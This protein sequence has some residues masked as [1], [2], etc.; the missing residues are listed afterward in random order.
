ME[1]ARVLLAEDDPDL[2][3]SLTD[4]L[5]D[6]GMKVVS[7][8]SGSE[9]VSAL[10]QSTFDVVVTDVLMP[11]P[12]GVQVAAMA[13]T[14]GDDVPFLVIT[15]LREPWIA[16]TVGQLQ[17]AEL[18]YKPFGYT[19]FLERVHALVQR[20]GSGRCDAAEDHSVSTA[21]HEFPPS[22]VPI[23]RERL[24]ISCITDMDDELLAELLT[25]VFFAGLETEEGE[26]NPV[27]VLFVGERAVELGTTTGSAPLYRWS[28]VRFRAGRHFSARE[29]VKLAAA[30]ASERVFTEVFAREGRLVIAGL[31]REG[32]NLEGDPF[33]KII[34]PKPGALSIRV[35]REHVLDYEHG[36][37]QAGGGDVILSAGPV[38]GA[39]AAAAAA[40][41]LPNDAIPA[42]LDAVHSL[43]VELSAHGRG[44][45][46]VISPE[47][48]PR[49][50]G[51][52]GYRTC[53]GISLVSLLERLE[54]RELGLGPAHAASVALEQILRGTFSSELER[55]IKELGALTALDGAT[56]LDRSLSLAGFGVVLPVHPGNGVVEALDVSATS[57]RPY[58]LSTRG[59]RH[60]AAAS[61]AREHP[62]SVVFVAS[63]DGHLGC[64][65]RAPEWEGVV[66]WR[67]RRFQLNQR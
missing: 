32:V 10:A 26:R 20:C 33:L 60:R 52:S 39:L 57:V 62:N 55:T 41:G 61:F 45:I 22:L 13:R 40:C 64:L 46:L 53:G 4:V 15:G 48:E 35:G 12:A 3:A 67:M 11:S 16:E 5:T 59:T 49:I 34:V 43:V 31:V 18:L 8:E 23:L 47:E 21:K 14:A 9:A 44:G 30:S 58:D 1:R 25:V 36:R 29:L 27:R 50:P 63:G 7:V 2:R 51:E 42:Y 38:Q 24:P 6:D 37:V 28:P 54:S 66:M 17:R 19:E 65:F 56:V